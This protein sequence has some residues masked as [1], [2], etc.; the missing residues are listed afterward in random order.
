[1]IKFRA[2]D[3]KYKEYTE[4]RYLFE[5]VPDG[6]DFDLVSSVDFDDS[7]GLVIEQYTGLKDVNGKEIYEGDILE[8]RKYRSIVK[9]AS[10]KFLADLIETIQTFDLIG[11]T[12]GSKVI[13]NVHENPELLKG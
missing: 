7:N 6:K 9:F 4:N 2:W 3:N 13:G 1:M 12:H 5:I 8:N 11:E 10:G